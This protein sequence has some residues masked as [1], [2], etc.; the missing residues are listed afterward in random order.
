[1]PA[2][3]ECKTQT[4]NEDVYGCIF[5]PTGKETNVARQLELFCPGVKATAVRQEKHQTENGVHSKIEKVVMSGYVFFRAKEEF[6]I[7]PIMHRAGALRVLKEENGQWRLFGENERFARWIFR[8]DGLLSFS[9]AYREGTRI[10]M[11]SGPLKDME[12]KITKVDK[13]GR[14]GQVTF[15]FNG[16]EMKVWLGFDLVEALEIGKN[17]TPEEAGK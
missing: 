15:A 6:D 8:Y 13:R 16:R 12:G 4:E 14:S 1:M 10:R 17:D 3:E 7:A 2:A 11:I 5:C 9:K